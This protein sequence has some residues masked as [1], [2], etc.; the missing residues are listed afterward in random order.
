VSRRTPGTINQSN[1][2]R[3]ARAMKA[4]GHSDCRIEVDPR[5]G[6]ISA[7]TPRSPTVTADGHDEPNEIDIILQRRKGQN[8]AM[9]RNRK[10]PVHEVLCRRRQWVHSTAVRQTHSGYQWRAK[11]GVVESLF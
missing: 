10:T 1:V 6:V 8:L 2:T 4:A 9:K 3:V 7:I 5:T 11:R